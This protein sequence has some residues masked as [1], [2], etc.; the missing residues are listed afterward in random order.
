MSWGRKPIFVLA[1]V[2]AGV[3]GMPSPELTGNQSQAAQ[4]IFQSYAKPLRGP[5]FSLED[6][7][8]K[9]VDI[10][11]YRGRV[12]LLNFWATW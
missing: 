6:L 3:L 9:T 11:D 10:R 4:S 8:G 5:E 12:I 1:L 2:G 7:Q